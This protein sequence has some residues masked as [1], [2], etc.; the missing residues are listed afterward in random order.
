MKTEEKYRRLVEAA[1]QEL[2][3]GINK[4]MEPTA[5]AVPM[6]RPRVFSFAPTIIWPEQKRDGVVWKKAKQ[7]EEVYS[8]SLNFNSDIDRLS[9]VIINKCGGQPRLILRALRRI[10]AATAWCYARAE[11]RRCMAEEILR[12]QARAVEALEA[13]AALAALK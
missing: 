9:K 4:L 8:Y 13:E 1:L 10:Q 3:G 12:Q 2:W 6:P 11:G 5:C 7:E